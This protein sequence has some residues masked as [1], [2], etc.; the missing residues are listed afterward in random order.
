MVAVPGVPAV[1]LVMRRVLVVRLVR[2]LVLT[3][4]LVVRHG[5]NRH[6]L[7]GVTTV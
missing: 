2:G 3:T 4:V 7:L 6:T 5:T 1:V